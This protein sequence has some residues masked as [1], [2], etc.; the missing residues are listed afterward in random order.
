[1]FSVARQCSRD[2]LVFSA[3]VRSTSSLL[4][5]PLMPGTPYS[6]LF[7]PNAAFPGYSQN[8]SSHPFTLSFFVH[9]NA[10]A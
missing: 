7:S 3:P 1:M 4:S 10:P 8:L 2:A 5:S 9:Q 6:T